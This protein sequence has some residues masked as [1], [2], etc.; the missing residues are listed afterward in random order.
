MSVKLTGDHI[1]LLQGQWIA[2]AKSGRMTADAIDKLSRL[3][4]SYGT[5]VLTAYVH[6]VRAITGCPAGRFMF[7]SRTIAGC[8]L[9]HDIFIVL[10]PDA[11]RDAR[12]T[13][14]QAQIL[15]HELGHFVNL[16]DLH[17]DSEHSRLMYETAA[18]NHVALEPDECR[19]FDIY[20][21]VPSASIAWPPMCRQHMSGRHLQTAGMSVL[22]Q[23]LPRAVQ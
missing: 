21:R 1:V 14:R 9:G 6:V 3:A 12:W 23:S 22:T 10:T 18:I 2:L 16:P 19:V 4:A 11:T 8:T 20:P 15:A 7:Q 5:D 13:T 17:G